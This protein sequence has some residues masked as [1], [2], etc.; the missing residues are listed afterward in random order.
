MTKLS[1]RIIALGVSGLLGLSA[2]NDS[3]KGE[4]NLAGMAMPVLATTVIQQDMPNTVRVFGNV[5]AQNDTAISS[6]ISGNIAHIAFKEGNL[7]KQGTVLVTIDSRTQQARLQQAK[8][9]AE[10]AKIELERAKNLFS[11]GA[12]S[13]QELD[14]ASATF[15]AREADVAIAQAE[16]DKTTITAPF[17][18][19]LGARNIAEGAYVSPGDVLVTV[20][21][22]RELKVRYSVGERYLSALKLN[23]A[24][25]LAVDAF[26]KEN[27][28]GTVDFISPTVDETSR[29]ILV[30]AVI[31][32]A[33]ERLSPGL[34]AVVTHAM[35]ITP[36]A[37][38]V[39]EEAL[40]A[41][42]EG[43]NVYRIF[44]DDKTEQLRV[45]KVLVDVGARA[46]GVVQIIN[47]L[48]ANDQIV[49]QGQQK[50]RDGAS[51]Q[52]VDPAKLKE[53]MEKGIN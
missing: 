20:V 7:V 25:S 23:Q 19:R 16:L 17:A 35:D 28:K 22:K 5:Y 52:I 53:K 44:K 45:Q 24:V 48:N 42:I 14:K 6:E 12:Q 46:D 47:R 51:V 9:D 41:S 3:S 8:A 50:L 43:Q 2:C 26:P 40:V 21:D 18:G 34:S 33:D 15:Q 32:N 37:L 4:Q 38:I 39:P 30:E 13:K 36:Q 1:I 11:R 10:L 31:P 27:F 49:V 29:S